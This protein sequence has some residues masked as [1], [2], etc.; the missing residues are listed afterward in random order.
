[1]NSPQSPEMCGQRP[2]LFHYIF[3]SFPTSACGCFN[4]LDRTSLTLYGEFWGVKDAGKSAISAPSF[5]NKR[6]RNWII[7][8]RSNSSLPYGFFNTCTIA[9]GSICQTTGCRAIPTAVIGLGGVHARSGDRNLS[10][11]GMGMCPGNK[12]TKLDVGQTSA[13]CAREKSGYDHTS[14]TPGVLPPKNPSAVP[15]K[16]KK[17]EWLRERD[18]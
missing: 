3:T 9:T 18:R 10:V 12:Q 6:K 8:T 14:P 4:C 2:L 7:E 17:Q 15:W 11:P 1:M 16:E 13:H 5:H